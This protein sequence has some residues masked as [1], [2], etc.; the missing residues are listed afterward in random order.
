[1]KSENTIEVYEVNGAEASNHPPII[2]TNY[3]HGRDRIVLEISKQK[4]TI[5]ADDLQRAIT[6]ACNNRN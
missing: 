6:N 4:Y 1:M 3:W 2:I 5:L